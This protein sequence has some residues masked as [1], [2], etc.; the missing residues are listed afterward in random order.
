MA[1]GPG[2]DLACRRKEARFDSKRRPRKDLK[3]RRDL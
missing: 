3:Q 1:G 2:P